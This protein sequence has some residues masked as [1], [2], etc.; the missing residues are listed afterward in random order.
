MAMNA[1]PILLLE[2]HQNSVLVS[3]DEVVLRVVRRPESSSW[4]DRLEVRIL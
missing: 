2:A 3:V 1:N 4:A